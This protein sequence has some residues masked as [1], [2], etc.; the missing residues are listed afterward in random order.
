[1]TIMSLFLFAYP[2]SIIRP[3]DALVYNHIVD[4]KPGIC[5]KLNIV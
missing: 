5:D 4:D 3:S 1:M 2:T